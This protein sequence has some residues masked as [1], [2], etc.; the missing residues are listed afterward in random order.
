MGTAVIFGISGQDGAYLS[1]QLLES[2]NR[3]VGV[4]RQAVDS[5]FGNL[6]TLGV[7][8]R[9]TL[10]QMPSTSLHDVTELIGRHDPD[11]IYCFSGPTSVAFS[12]QQPHVALR[13]VPVATCLILE[14]IR[15]E[16]PGTRFLNAGSSECFGALDG[17]STEKTPFR[18]K[19][20]YG[21]AKAYCHMVTENY[22]NT[23]GLH[24][25]TAILFNHESPI[26]GPEF[27]TRKIARSVAEIALGLRSDFQLGNL[28]ARRDWGHAADYVE[29]MW[30]MLQQ[31][32]PADYVLA[33][34][35]SH[36]I[37]DFVEA[38][39]AHVGRSLRW[40]GEGV[41]ETGADAGT[42]QQL[43]AVDPN[44]FRPHEPPV[45][46]G[47]PAKAKA[48]LGWVPKTSFPDLVAEMV[49]SELVDIRRERA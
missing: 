10:K 44:Y 13:E 43:V 27:V 2:G 7:R 31:P 35:V 32:S 42:G 28:N 30:R 4:S 8:D 26:R 21:V 16:R 39:F 25:S 22:R 24:A 38:A 47:N 37:R 40:S 20:P 48:E 46:I 23:F 49:E 11:E 19:S 6:R 1:R 17:V 33:S 18:P 45:Q 29:G 12:Y 9:V 3:V 5:E 15:L 41:S 34:G 36:S 14:A